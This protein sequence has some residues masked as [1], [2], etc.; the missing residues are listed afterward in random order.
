MDLYAP[1]DGTM[2][3]LACETLNGNLR[4][5]LYD[6]KRNCIIFEDNCSS[7][8]IEFSKDYINLINRVSRK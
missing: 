8:G 5:S 7:A 4:V 6:K 2:K 1:Y 3:P